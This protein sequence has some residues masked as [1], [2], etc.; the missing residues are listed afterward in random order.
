MIPSREGTSPSSSQPSH[1]ASLL[2]SSLHLFLARPP[3]DSLILH[4][5]F[6]SHHLLPK[7]T[8]RHLRTTNPPQWHLH[9]SSHERTTSKSLT[10]TSPPNSTSFPM[11]FTLPPTNSFLSRDRCPY[12]YAPYYSNGNCYSSRGGDR[13]NSWGRWV[14][15]VAV[16]IFFLF[17]F[18]IIAC[19]NARRRRRAGR[20]PYRGT[21]WL[22]GQ[23][24]PGHA[25]AQY[26]QSPYQQQQ[27]AAT[28]GGYQA[29]PPQYGGQQQDGGYYGQQQQ[30]HQGSN[31]GYYGG[32]QQ[33]VELQ[34]PEV[35]YQGQA[36]QNV[37]QP[38][39]GPP[40]GKGDGVV[41]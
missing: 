27:Q 30:Q 3:S 29:P 24:P 17:I 34:S 4:H 28:S 13:W 8:S 19:I 23:T 6:K 40:P 31:Q 16:I 20:N 38:P 25:P 2:R 14:V 32:Q 35:A 26:T 1:H 37:Y 22:A 10:A 41:R 18:F 9:L 36:G 33:G 7:S 5:L 15:V 21:G 12:S 11:R 39:S